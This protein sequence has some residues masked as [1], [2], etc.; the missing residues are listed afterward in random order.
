MAWPDRTD[1]RTLPATPAPPPALR[2]RVLA[3]QRRRYRQRRLAWLALP[4]LAVLA[5]LPQA[6][7]GNA[8]AEPWRESLA[9]EAAWRAQADFAWLQ[10]DA[11]ARYLL[12]ELRRLD[13]GLARA[14]GGEA[15]AALWQ[16]RARAFAELLASRRDG[17]TAVLL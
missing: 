12:D 14:P 4:L 16:A 11:R 6:P 9:L 3:T 2:A 5:L 10:R 8:P 17:R 1:L 15:A 7:G 13:E